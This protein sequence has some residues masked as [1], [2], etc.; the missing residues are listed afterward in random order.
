MKPFD[1]AQHLRSCRPWIAARRPVFEDLSARFTEQRPERQAIDLGL[2]H[3]TYH[4]PMTLGDAPFIKVAQRL[5][6]L[7]AGP[8]GMHMEPWVSYDCVLA[9]GMMCGLAVPAQEIWPWLRRTLEVDEGTLDYI[10]VSAATLTPMVN[11]HSWELLNVASLNLVSPGSAPAGLKR[12]TIG[13][14]GELL[15]DVE[16]WVAVRWQNPLLNA[17]ASM[18]RLQLLTAWT[19]AQDIPQMTT[20]KFLP[21]KDWGRP[22]RTHFVPQEISSAGQP[23]VLFPADDDNA[24]QALQRDIEAGLQ[25]RI[26]GPAIEQGLRWFYPLA[27]SAESS[28]FLTYCEDI[29][30]LDAD[31]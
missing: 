16:L 17:L 1:L 18:T 30:G 28:E 31:H 6:M 12:L 14:V 9:P 5:Q 20:L 4:S 10:P 13:L 15:R 2:D 7:A 22:L 27:I 24:L 29:R 23:Q 19:P 11:A 25:V 8:L 21:D 26:L 3:L